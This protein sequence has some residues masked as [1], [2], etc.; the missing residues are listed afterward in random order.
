[1][2]LWVIWRVLNRLPNLLI[3]G[4][5]LKSR[6][7]I[8]GP[9]LLKICLI[10][11][12]AHFWGLCLWLNDH[13]RVMLLIMI[14]SVDLL[15]RRLTNLIINTHGILPEL[16]LRCCLQKFWFNFWINIFDILPFI[17]LPK[18]LGAYGKKFRVEQAL[19]ESIL[20]FLKSESIFFVVVYL[21]LFFTLLWRFIY[22]LRY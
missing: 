3:L 19:V 1:M 6:I 7:N 18:I 4:H 11:L 21:T 10:N 20:A 9:F 16:S 15:N 13:F 22:I 2:F 8:D 14:C 17:G 12:I 5:F